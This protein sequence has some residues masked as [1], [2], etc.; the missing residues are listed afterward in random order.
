[1]A[2]EIKTQ[3]KWAIAVERKMQKCVNVNNDLPKRSPIDAPPNSL[4]DS[5][6]NPKVEQWKDKE[7]GYVP[8][9]VALQVTCSQAPY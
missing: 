2:N 3:V 7:L 9:L 4:I 5:T 1:L 6:L 8:C